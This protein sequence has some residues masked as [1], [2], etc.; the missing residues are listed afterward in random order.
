MQP[1]G[2]VRP[3]DIGLSLAWCC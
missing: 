2:E 1:G 3:N